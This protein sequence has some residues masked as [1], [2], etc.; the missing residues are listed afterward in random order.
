MKKKLM[1]IIAAAAMVVTMVPSMVFAEV[2]GTGTDPYVVKPD[3]FAEFLLSADSKDSVI[4]LSAGDYEFQTPTASNFCLENITI[5]G[6]DGAKVKGFTI[7][8]N[9]HGVYKVDGLTFKN[10]IFEGTAWL[11]ADDMKNITF[12]GCTFKNDAQINQNDPNEHISNLVIK[13]CKFEGDATVGNTTNTAIMVENATGLTID[14]CTF[15]KIDYNAMQ[16][17]TLNGKVVVT[18]NK[19]LSTGSRNLYFTKDNMTADVTVSGNTFC[20]PATPKA[21]GNFIKSNTAIEIGSN[22]YP[23]ELPVNSNEYITD[24]ITIVEDVPTEPPTPITPEASPATG[25]NSKVPF[26][27]AGLALAAMAAAVA[28]RRRTN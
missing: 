19:I 23:I 13:N 14:N 12:D 7:Y 9:V 6:A 3:N 22:T 2:T 15:E 4:K 8:E 20:I 16:L 1:A 24:N 25:D 11:S 17:C 10:V 18:N 27:V 5:V 26:A 28:T 21:D